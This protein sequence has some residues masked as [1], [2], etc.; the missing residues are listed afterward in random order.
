MNEWEEHYQAA[1]FELD[2]DKLRT[3]IDETRQAIAKRLAASARKQTD[4]GVKERRDIANA[5][6]I[7]TVLERLLDR[8]AGSSRGRIKNDL[9]VLTQRRAS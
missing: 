8:S 2:D 4:L 6:E 9:L 3:K 7:L 1:V 5:L